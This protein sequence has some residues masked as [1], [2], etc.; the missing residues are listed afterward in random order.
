M[1]TDANDAKR[2]LTQHGR[3]IDTKH[4]ITHIIHICP[5]MPFFALKMPFFAPKMPFFA[6]EMPFFVPKSHFSKKM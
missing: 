5:N 6:P 1:A 4:S 2:M 3:K